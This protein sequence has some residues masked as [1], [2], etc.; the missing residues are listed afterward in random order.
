MQKGLKLD[1]MEKG[2]FEKRLEGDEREGQ[3]EV[4]E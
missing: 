1:P 4:P 3:H 2:T